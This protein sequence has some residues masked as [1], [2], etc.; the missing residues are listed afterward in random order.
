MA[1]LPGSKSWE[2]NG[3]CLGLDNGLYEW[4]WERRERRGER[5][6]RKL[7]SLQPT[8]I[9]FWCDT[10]HLS[11][12]FP[13]IYPFD[14][15]L[16]GLASWFVV[17]AGGTMATEPNSGELLLKVDP[18][19]TSVAFASAHEGKGSGAGAARLKR[20]EGYDIILYPLSY[21]ALGEKVGERLRGVRRG[22]LDVVKQRFIQG[23][24]F[25]A[26]WKMKWLVVVSAGLWTLSLGV[27]GRRLCLFVLALSFGFDTKSLAEE[28][29]GWSS[30]PLLTLSHHQARA[31]VRSPTLSLHPLRGE[32]KAATTWLRV[33]PVPVSVKPIVITSW[34]L[35]TPTPSPSRPPLTRSPPRTAQALS[36][37]L[38]L[39][40]RCQACGPEWFSLFTRLL[41]PVFNS[42]TTGM[43]LLMTFSFRF[44]CIGLQCR[45]TVRCTEETFSRETTLV[46]QDF[47]ALCCTC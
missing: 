24:E 2:H 14:K 37:L 21:W 31:T 30:P 35:S 6:D 29:W 27:G 26:W 12:R 20:R 9:Y 28:S 47:V 43:M 8:V 41:R 36:S 23:G 38:L 13:F 17:P 46:L 3:P 39:S 45:N 40:E 25:L 22:G 19:R 16:E 11:L 44:C 7:P 1:C 33:T 15:R 34:C 10:F 18:L 4:E 42:F 5:G 32:W